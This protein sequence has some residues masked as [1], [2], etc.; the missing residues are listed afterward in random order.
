MI[1]SNVCNRRVEAEQLQVLRRQI[2]ALNE[3][4]QATMQEAI[5]DLRLREEE[6]TRSRA[7]IEQLEAQL[8]IQNME[9]TR[10]HDVK[11]SDTSKISIRAT[12]LPPSLVI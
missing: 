12:P 9:V 6:L 8:R 2:M 11:K 7:R 3:E 5:R 10:M 4:K 1:A